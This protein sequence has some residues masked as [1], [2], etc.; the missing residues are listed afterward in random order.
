MAS[1]CSL[2]VAR[3]IRA[4]HDEADRLLTL[5]A[6]V[7]RLRGFAGKAGVPAQLRFDGRPRND[8]GISVPAKPEQPIPALQMPANSGVG[9]QIAALLGF[10]ALS[11]TVS[12]LGSLAIIA[13]AHGWYAA[14]NKAPWT[15]PTG[16]SG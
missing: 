2:L 9:H 15:P 7:T 11:H 16:T 6:S 14:A 8:Q 10:L 3:H 5:K 12:F 1:V 4:T 13:N